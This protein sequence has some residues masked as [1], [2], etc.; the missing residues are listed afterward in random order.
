[1][2]GQ[3]DPGDQ[4]IAKLAGRQHGVVARDQLRDLGFG[5]K[6][7]DHRVARGR[8]HVIH[9][10]VY[11]VGHRSLS[12]RGRWM[13]AVLACGPDAVLSHR[14]AAALWGIRPTSRPVIEVTVPRRGGRNREG[15]HRV[16]SL[17]PED[18]AVVD[19]IPVTSI[20]RTLLD[21]AEVVT[22]RELERAL[23][24]AERKRLFDLR[25][26]ERLLRRSRGRRGVKPLRTALAEYRD[27]PP[28]TKSEL[29]RLFLDFC[30]K[31]RLPKPQVNTLVEGYE[32]DMHWPGTEVIVELD[33]YAF[34]S[35][36]AA[37]ERDRERDEQLQLRDYRILRV[38]YRRLTSKPQELAATLTTLLADQRRRR[39]APRWRIR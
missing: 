6:A 31:F 20:A 17:H 24:E 37:F 30:K 32:V 10:G 12:P 33:G 35:T 23:E 15:V 39:P 18:C 13:A 2:R 5:A 11:A 3:I 7:I 4:A 25:A 26:V 1:M 38:T 19:G 22:R 36:R 16:R 14:S 21:L 29:E 8:L 28:L 9:R 27:E 34:H